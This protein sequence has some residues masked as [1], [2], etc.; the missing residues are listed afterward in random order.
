MVCPIIAL[1]QFGKVWTTIFHFVSLPSHRRWFLFHVVLCWI[2]KKEIHNTEE[3]LV[4][5]TFLSKFHWHYIK[6]MAGQENTQSGWIVNKVHSFGNRYIENERLLSIEKIRLIQCVKSRQY[7]GNKINFDRIEVNLYIELSNAVEP[8]YDKF[9][10][11]FC[12]CQCWDDRGGYEI[13]Y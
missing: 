3:E 4:C 5:F 10:Y 1:N 13:N 2:T 7:I 11:C 8:V 12:H 6:K 9:G